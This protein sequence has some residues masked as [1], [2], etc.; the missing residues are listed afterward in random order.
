[1]APDQE[2][3]ED[4]LAIS[5]QSSIKLWYVYVLIRIVSMS[6]HNIHIHDKIRTLP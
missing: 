1:M 2:V 5:F 6:T 3:N 4:K